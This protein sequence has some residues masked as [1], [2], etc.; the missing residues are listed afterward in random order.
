MTT[1]HVFGP[2]RLDVEAEILFRGTEPLPVGKRAVALMRAL[3]ERPGAPVS[4]GALID[5]AWPGISVEESNLPVQIGQLRRVLAAEPGGERW[6]ETLPRRGYR[7]VGPAVTRGE[8]DPPVAAAPAATPVTAAAIAPASNEPPHPALPDKPSLAVLPFVHMGRDPDQAYFCDAIADDLITA[9][10]R[11]RWLFVIARTSSFT[12]KGRYTDIKQI[13]RELGVRYVLEGGVRADG[14]RLRVT[15]QL[16]DAETGAHVWAGRY[17]RVRE[18]IFAIQDEITDAIVGALEPEISTIER[19]RARQKPPENLGAW[20]LYHRAMWH[21]LRHNRDDYVA[22]RELF[23]RSIACDAGFAAPHAGLAVCWWR[24][25]IVHDF[26]DGRASPIDALHAASAKAVE[27]DAKDALAHT[28]L[29]LALMERREYQSAI[30]QQEVARDLNPNSAFGRWCYGYALHRARRFAD[31]LEQFEAAIRLSP[32]D[33]ALWSFLTMKAAAMYYLERYESAAQAAREAVRHP[34]VDLVWPYVYLAAST[35]QLGTTEEARHAIEQL[36]RLRPGLTIS[37]FRTWP[38][39]EVR[40]A[41]D[42]DHLTDGLAK[43]GLPA[44]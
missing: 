29:G 8:G 10:S 9:L 17:E 13:G 6:I 5:A 3:I 32:R 31:A 33:P 38:L 23:E 2:F 24:F 15:A 30:E 42:L 22:A 34:V 1:I 18:D 41:T 25:H 36:C 21:F 12:Y 27:L 39:N 28:A 44:G 35:G 37:A 40:D 7:F 16:I 26:S 20:E 14:G 43:A 4:K 19:E 11:L